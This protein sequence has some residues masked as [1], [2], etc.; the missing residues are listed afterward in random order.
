MRYQAVE[1]EF[2]PHTLSR[3]SDDLLRRWQETV[4][5]AQATVTKATAIANPMDAW[6]LQMEFGMRN[7][8]RWLAWAENA[9][10]TS[11]APIAEPAPMAPANVEPVNLEPVDTTPVNAEPAEMPA[12]TAVKV[13]LASALEAAQPLAT[14]PVAI[15]EFEEETAQQL[16]SRQW[17]S[18]WPTT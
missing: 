10:A 6:S 2:G 15:V 11:A 12:P 16:M 13:P 1:F 17:Q 4:D 3:M 8:Q 7:A 5:D 9:A 14:E 18:Q